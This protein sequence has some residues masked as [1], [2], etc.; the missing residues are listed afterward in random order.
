MR[1][2]SIG[3]LGSALAYFESEGYVVFR[4]LVPRDLLARFWDEVE[5]ARRD[6]GELLF[7]GAEGVKPGRET[8]LTRAPLPRIV[9]IQSFSGAAH[10]VALAPGIA[11]YLRKLYGTA[12]TCI[13]TLTYVHSSQQAEHSDLHLVSPPYVG[14]YDR[15][16]LAAAW[17][18]IEPATS[19]NGPLIVYPRSHRIPK[20]R[21]A[22]D[23]A[24]DYA[25]YVAHLRTLCARH[26]IEGEVFLAEPGDVLFWHGDL[27]HAGS[28]IADAERMPT[29]AS[30]VCHYA[31]LPENASSGDPGWRV[32]R[33]ADG[34]IFH[35]APG[36]RVPKPAALA[37][38]PR[39]RFP[40][41]SRRPARP[42]AEAVR[43]ART[44]AAIGLSP[45]GRLEGIVLDGEEPLKPVRVDIA[46]DGTPF[47]SEL[48]V[49][50]VDRS[51]LEALGPHAAG[52]IRAAIGETRVLAAAFSFDIPDYVPRNGVLSILVRRCGT[53]EVLFAERFDAGSQ[54]R[55]ILGAALSEPLVKF[56]PG[57]IG[58]DEI[59]VYGQ[60]IGRGEPECAV[61]GASLAAFHAEAVDGA[62]ELA[63]APEGTACRQFT[64]RLE[65]FATGRV[66]RLAVRPRGAPDGAAA[67]GAFHVPPD[68]EA[69]FARWAVPGADAIDRVA[70]T[71]EPSD[72]FLGGYQSFRV[73]VDVLAG[74][75]GRAIEPGTAIL[76]FGCGVGRL[77][78]HLLYWTDA[79][80]TG[81]DIDPSAIAWM[82]AHM[83]RGV[84]RRAPLDPPTELSAESFDVAVAISVF[85]HLAERDQLAWLAELWRLLKPGGHLVATVAS[86][87]GALVRPH[88]VQAV[89][90]LA[91]T[92]IDDGAIGTALADVL[93]A[94]RADYYRETMQSAAYVAARWSPWFRLLGVYE[95]S[96]FGLQDHLVL[97]RRPDAPEPPRILR[98]P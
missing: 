79:R 72:Y 49:G 62:P 11:A 51:A 30:L 36:G 52:R 98:L 80:V 42:L 97:E 2:F 13:Q 94:E 16:S 82:E 55:R 47:R 46:I 27:I 26:G 40:L 23:F 29:R 73:L 45:E 3:E 44:E 12:P 69:V 56:R 34:A 58:A 1:Q 21:L 9:D 4:G 17:I 15:A 50:L 83:P 18:A 60:Y 75:A 14:E 61:D 71:R 32:A 74:A 54:A 7:G 43:P 93:P 35:R 48:C 87:R 86:V 77:A 66:A 10:D 95:G 59:T 53:E 37:R 39:Y 81:L 24:G 25:A 8:D 84:W 57:A 92:G 68:A 76:D 22:E 19:E 78:Q 5:R 65:D 89:L 64:A 96:H 85:T 6:E 90:R 67:G 88:P 41:G 28:S 70:R 31:R 33:Y 91:R 38:A 20:K 63:Y